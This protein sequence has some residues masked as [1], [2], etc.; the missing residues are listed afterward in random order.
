MNVGWYD[1]GHT[2]RHFPTR[3]IVWDEVMYE[4][5]VPFWGGLT[6]AQMAD[7]FWWGAAKGVYVGHSETVLSNDLPAYD[8]RQPLW[9]A[10]GGA[11]VGVAVGEA[12]G[13]ALCSTI[14]Q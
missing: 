8:D 10:K 7:R 13:E 3:P 5:D 4:G 9:W 1:V 14:F 2:K 6:A 11:L 12:V